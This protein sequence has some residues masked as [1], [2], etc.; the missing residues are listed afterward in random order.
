[1][2]QYCRSS[3]LLRV[4]MLGFSILTMGKVAIAQLPTATI[5]GTVKDS[6]GAV[7]PGAAI[8][9]KNL[10]TDLTR[11]GISAEDGSY[12][13][14][15]LPVG[16]Y[17]MRVEL[18][19][20]RTEVRSGLT[21]TVSQ[22]AVV[23]FTMRAGA[24][25]Q[26]LVVTEDAP[27]VNTTSGTLGGLVD[28]QKVAELPLNG[29]NFI[30]LTLLQPGITQHRDAAVAASTVGLW[31]SSNGAPLRS[32][33]YLLDGAIMTNL[34]QGT[35]ASQDGSTLGIEG[36]REYRVI[37]NS[38]SAE[39]GMTMG[40]QVVMVT[41]GGTN[42][43]HGSL[44][45]YFRN[46]ALD[47]RNFFDY[48]TAASNR[49]LPAFARNQFGGSIGGPI[50]KDKTFFFVVYE[51]LR[52]HL[53]V[54]TVSNVMPA[55]CHT[56]NHVVDR[57]CVSTL[58]AG[59]TLTVAPIVQP[60][61]DLFPAPNLSGNKFTF[62]FTQPTRDDY[63]Q[64]RIDH[65]F[66]AA[67]SLFGR[68]TVEDTTVTDPLNY[69]QFRTLRFSRNEYTTVSEN[70]IFSPAL[71][72]TVRFS[73]SRTHPRNP[74]PSGLIGP[75]YSF[76][77]G[78]E[79]GTIN[80]GGVTTM[81][82][83]TAPTDFS[84]RVFTWSG[85]FFYTRGRH[86]LKLGT[87]VNHFRQNLLNNNNAVG[88]VTFAN[89]NNFLLGST[90]QYSVLTPG[91]IRYRTYNY[92]TLGF[93][94][95]DDLRVLPNLTFN[96]G[97]RYEFLTVPNELTGHGSAIRDIQRDDKGTLGPPFRNSS[98]LSLSPRFGFAWN[99]TG[100]GKTAVRGGFA[101]LYDIGVMGVSLAIAAIGTPPFSSFSSVATPAPLTL[102]FSF[103]PSV[104]GKS[105]RL[106]DY[107][108]KQPHI[109][110][111][112]LTLERQLPWQ[113]GLTL[114]YAGSRGINIM[115]I[116]DGNPTIPQILSDGRKFWTGNDPRVNPNWGA[117]ELHTAGAN[118]W[119]NALQFGV[120]KR[121]TNGLQFQSSYTWSKL[122]DETQGQAGADNQVSNLFGVDPSNRRMDRGLADFDMRH[123]WQFN[124]IYLVPTPF[125]GGVPA[126]V[127][128][129]WRASSILSVQSGYPFTPALRTNR[130]RSGVNA[131]GGGQGAGNIDRPNLVPGRTKKDIILGG[132]NRYF[133][134]TAFVLQD[135][136][137]LGTSGRNYLTG[138]GY[139]NLDLSL[140]K[141][142]PLKQLGDSGA[143][144]F[145]GEFFNILNHAN[146]AMTD[147]FRQV[148]AGNATGEAPLPTAGVITSTGQARSRQI[149][150]A[151][152]LLF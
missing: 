148:F 80:I 24:V 20:F 134:P 87:L 147:T 43:L 125:K 32:N 135:A 27:L 53:G 100:D 51:G 101:E 49:R 112:N 70:H 12:Q 140:G 28:E 1:M 56:P 85:D 91:S 98:L 37:T 99:V 23:N 3:M 93:Y 102:P 114:G 86:S 41:K 82:P 19:G 95:Q 2:V 124:T 97:L 7:I 45:E 47:A 52:Q 83:N 107:N 129:G 119:Y 138:P 40:S 136:G 5:L 123:N 48:K 22:E 106:L 143:L 65:I 50:K 109:L 68:Y 8:S 42:T 149:Q 110:D 63:G 133:D 115:K 146:F 88:T 105:L 145:R 14:S 89:V 116:T 132:P 66:S 96:L 113:M 69:P 33:N 122:I 126:A 30:D 67:D 92:N 150:F 104:L 26:T 152:K 121:L 15:A 25:D 55:A 131:G 77:Q 59:Q 75:Q 84:Q 141:N 17:E 34:T 44:F 78:E 94:A 18:P 64:G 6:T 61:L 36:I 11:T 128:G 81:G 31:F 38:F 35:S 16:S 72:A 29:R 76:V 46:S 117:I 54:T 130:S 71:L 39:Y 144:E 62:P 73:L 57:N 10:E 9:A 90:S 127:L 118:S 13:F 139:F 151:L 111:Y 137:F 142:I 108:L 103:S 58:A 4:I 120:N 21:L 74:S 60:I 79:I